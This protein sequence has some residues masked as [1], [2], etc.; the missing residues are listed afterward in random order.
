MIIT[1][2]R[3]QLCCV[4]ARCHAQL[5]LAM[6]YRI[7]CT[8][9]SLNAIC[10][11][12]PFAHVRWKPDHIRARRDLYHIL[13]IT[14]NFIIMIMIINVYI[15]SM[16]VQHTISSKVLLAFGRACPMQLCG[17]RENW[18]CRK[19]TF[20]NNDQ[21]LVMR[22]WYH[23][24][25]PEAQERKKMRARLKFNPSSQRMLSKCAIFIEIVRPQQKL[26]CS[27]F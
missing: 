8:T 4:V 13:I 27:K 20:Q 18:Q 14:I 17:K 23:I 24:S 26:I 12:A 16:S 5:S 10:N 6:C 2:I 19:C 9:I 1:I 25:L 3:M 15:S 21:N 22:C 11:C 7:E